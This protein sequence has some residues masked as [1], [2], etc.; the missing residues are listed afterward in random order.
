MAGNAL[1]IRGLRTEFPGAQGPVAVVDDVSLAVREGEM[2]AVVGESGSGKTM[3][4]LSALGM[5][6]KP[7][8]V[9][10]GQVLLNG[11]DLV[12]LPAD[13]LRH[14]RGAVISMVFQDPLSGLN[15]V[16]SVGD[17]IVEV[18]RAHRDVG[19]GEARRMAI[20]LLERVQIPDAARRVDDYPHQF[21]G[22]MRQRV[23][24][25]MAIALS[26]KVLIA[27]EPTTALDVTVQAQVL[28]LLDSLRRD[29]GMAIVLITHDLG[30]V[31]RHADRMV[32][33]YAGS[34]VEEGPVDT[35]FASPSHPYTVSLLRSIPR[36]DSPAGEVLE[37][38]A[39]QPPTA[40][41]IRTGCRF[42]PRCFLANGRADCRDV[43][44]V[45][46]SLPDS[47][48]RTACHHHSELPR[49]GGRTTLERVA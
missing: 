10:A 35:V 14:L 1:E 39:G 26:P 17:Q 16:F 37:S 3:T 6:A 44:P 8:R 32:V 45:L 30:I 15:P 48:Q 38:I 20:D 29:S 5:V 13:A 11:R 7:G 2:L 36:L 4:F 18:I 27:D 21:S 19:A 43:A 41:S 12:G 24:T 42:Q 33:M 22:G 28:D 49:T 9:V 46:S 23:L 40:G 47:A 31:A 34:V 25:A